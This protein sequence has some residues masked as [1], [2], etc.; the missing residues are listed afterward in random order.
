MAAW[1]F[2]LKIG[3]SVPGMVADD[4]CG[5]PLNEKTLCCLLNC[6]VRLNRKKN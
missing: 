4:A 5:M 1:I 2:L 3:S 6:G